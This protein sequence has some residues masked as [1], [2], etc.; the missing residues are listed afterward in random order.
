MTTFLSVTLYVPAGRPVS[1]TGSL[2]GSLYTYLPDRPQYTYNC[3]RIRQLP[4]AQISGPDVPS[5]AASGPQA[6]FSSTVGSGRSV[7]KPGITPALARIV[8]PG[9]TVGENAGMYRSSEK[10]FGNR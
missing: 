7:S 6:S 4:P 5:F 10:S 1:D 3:K 9:Y 8:C 2:I